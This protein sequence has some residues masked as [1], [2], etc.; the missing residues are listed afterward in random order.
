MPEKIKLIYSYDKTGSVVKGW[1]P[2]RTT[3][4]VKA[5]INY[6]KVSGKDYIVASDEN[7]IYFLD[8]TGNKRINLKEP[9]TKAAGSAM[10]LNLRIRTIMLF[11]HR[12]MVQFSIYILM[13]VLK[14]SV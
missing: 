8:R 5:E 12:L 2:F 1:K 7:S 10:R 14:N 6:F 3:G 13:E 11:V 9:V 4:S